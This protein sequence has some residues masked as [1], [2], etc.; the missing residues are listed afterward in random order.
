MECANK[1]KMSVGSWPYWREVGK[2]SWSDT[3]Q[4]RHRSIPLRI[5]I[6]EEKFR[7]VD[8]L[9]SSWNQV[10]KKAR[11]GGKKKQIK[12]KNNFEIGSKRILN[13]TIACATAS[14][15]QVVVA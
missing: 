15:T 13:F 10:E 3:R 7:V 12:I 2:R 6:R 4:A 14:F 11:N 9:C 1:R 5:H 8:S